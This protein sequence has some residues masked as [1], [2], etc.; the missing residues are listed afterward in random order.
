MWNAHHVSQ[1]I[2]WP[3]KDATRDLIALSV[4]GLLGTLVLN[5]GSIA[6][7]VLIIIRAQLARSDS[8]WM[9]S[10]G[11]VPSIALMGTME[12]SNHGFA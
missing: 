4:I 5:A 3:I 10:Q 2:S 7:S 9:L 8:F 11:F 12:T 1:V 6:I